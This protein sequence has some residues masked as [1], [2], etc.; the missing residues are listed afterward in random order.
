MLEEVVDLAALL[1]DL[2]W[3]STDTRDAFA[4]TLEGEQL[5]RVL[6]HIQGFARHVMRKHLQGAQENSDVSF[7]FERRQVMDMV[8]AYESIRAQAETLPGS[9]D[10]EAPQ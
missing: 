2:G 1:N 3:A 6:N 8:T 5:E 4:I 10:L 7:E 9:K